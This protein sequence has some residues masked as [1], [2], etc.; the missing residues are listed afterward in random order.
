MAEHHRIKYS[1]EFYKRALLGET[2]RDGTKFSGLRSVAEKFKAADGYDLRHIEEWTPAQRARV[3]K[4]YHELQRLTA[5]P[6][7]VFRARNEQHLKQAQ[8]TSGHDTGY[9][10]KV[11]FVPYTPEFDKQGKL[12]PPQVEFLKEG[13][14]IKQTGYNK[15]KIPF[16]KVNLV[17]NPDKEITRAIAV[18]APN[19]KRFAI[20]ANGNEMRG[21]YARS[22]VTEKVVQL[23]EKYDGIRPLP[24]GS[25]NQGNNPKYHKWDQWLD[26]LVGYEFA[27]RSDQVKKT[28]QAVNKFDEARQKWQ[29]KRRRARRRHERKGD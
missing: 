17:R 28:Q 1:K 7:Y 22:F 25:G 2:A 23:M 12:K 8:R 18:N 5:Q 20:D 9:K 11:A 29:N 24:K 14:R 19:A 4:Y 15:L 21:I 27:S 6:R 16:N 13:I 10:F 26:G 3:R